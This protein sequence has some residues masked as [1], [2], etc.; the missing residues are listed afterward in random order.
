MD[1]VILNKASVI[2]RCVRRVKEEYAGD[3]KH[4]Y[5]DFTRQ[6]SIILNL[7]RACEASIDLAA[8][9]VK[10]RKLGV[11]QSSRDLFDLLAKAGLMTSALASRL[12]KMVGFR[13][14]AVHDY[15]SIELV[16]VE[17]II[18]EHLGDFS[19]FAQAMLKAEA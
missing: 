16:I 7:Q 15:I 14:V 10:Q 1:D 13:N 6:D 17:R 12:Q 11:P 8:F 2:E 9:C 18:E 3:V 19:D 5:N 4:L